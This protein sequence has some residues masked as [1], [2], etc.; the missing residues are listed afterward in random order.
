MWP[1]VPEE[2]HQ[3]PGPAPAAAAPQE[4]LSGDGQLLCQ[5]EKDGRYE[6]GIKASLIIINQLSCLSSEPRGI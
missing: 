6:G 4:V 5:G 1:E 2:V 3:A